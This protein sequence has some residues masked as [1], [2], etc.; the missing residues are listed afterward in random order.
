[1]SD[2]PTDLYR[3]DLE[4]IAEQEAKLVLPDFDEEFAWRL[5]SWLRDTARTHS[6]PIAIDVRRTQQRLFS[7]CLPGTVPDNLRWIERKSNTVLH[8][9]RSSYAVGLSLKQS[10]QTLADRYALADADYC[11]HGGAFP[12]RLARGGFIGCVCVSGLPQ[13]AD[14]GLV[15]DSLCAM[16]GLHPEPLRLE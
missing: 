3:R 4:R 13:R 11:T 5:G 15:V 14:H 10:G 12:L 16:L 9:H 6:Y 7:T 2:N 8:F 1:M